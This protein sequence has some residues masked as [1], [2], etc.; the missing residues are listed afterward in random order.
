MNLFFV[1]NKVCI[2]ICIDSLY[3]CVQLCCVYGT[4]P[5]I[6]CIFVIM[7]IRL[8]RCFAL[9]LCINAVFSSAIFDLLCH[10]LSHISAFV[11]HYEFYLLLCSYV[12][13]LG[14]KNSMAHRSS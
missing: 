3:A 8:K 5:C 6:S 1:L 7:H 2:A 12:P 14:F 13:N 4:W 10:S 9:L 11:S